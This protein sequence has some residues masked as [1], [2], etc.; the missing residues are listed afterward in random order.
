MFT[1][2]ERTLQILTSLVDSN[3][4]LAPCYI[5]NQPQL[6]SNIRE[7]HNAFNEV[8][9]PR[10]KIGYSYK[11]NC[12]KFVLST[13]H[14][15]NVYAEIVSPIEFAE[16]SRNVS[17]D[18]IIYNGVIPDLENKFSV[19]KAGG[20]VNVENLIELKA[21]DKL[22]REQMVILD[23]GIRINV[24]VD[25]GELSRFGIEINDE[26]LKEINQLTNLH[27]VGIHSHLSDSR[28]IAFWYNKVKAVSEVGRM[29]GIEVI[30]LGGRL[31]GPMHPEVKKRFKDGV[32]TFRDYAETIK[33]A[34]VEV[35][36]T[37]DKLPTIIVEPG[38]ALI[39]NAVSLI[40]KVVDVK[41]VKNKTVATLNCK[42]RDVATFI[43]VP[44][45][46]PYKVLS[47]GREEVE[48][49]TI[50]GCTC[51][52]HDV[53]VEHYSGK[54]SIGD[55][56]VF[57]NVGS[58]SSSLSPDF[59]QETPSYLLYDGNTFYKHNALPKRRGIKLKKFRFK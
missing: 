57:D 10:Y 9:G 35:Y 54:L 14:K 5:L 51:V 8:F 37:D 32:P 31:Y 40:A 2:T 28:S 23:V 41:T 3:G 53:F 55:Y 20:L 47:K 6:Q 46:Y 42:S 15:E 39:S 45:N 22:A 38:T 21:L 27:I 12:E 16:A 30:D 13:V 52:E 4:Q 49:A 7:L 19:A 59:I 36:G 48:D 17:L 26:N 1:T 50:Y 44:N 11:T 24:D 56:V 33:S 58:Y 25:G 34:L 43:D 18:R 29:L